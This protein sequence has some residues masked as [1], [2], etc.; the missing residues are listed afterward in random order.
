VNRLLDAEIAVKN[1]GWKWI[2]M[3]GIREILIP[4]DNSEMTN[5][6]AMW[7]KDG[8]PH[9]LP[10]YSRY[11]NK[12]YA[13]SGH[14]GAGKT[15]IMRTI[16]GEDKEIVSVTTRPMREGEVDGVDYYYI[17]QED[18]DKLDINGELAEKTTYYGRAS[19]GVTKAEINSKL[20]KSNTYIIVDYN[21]MKQLKNI[22]PNLVSIFIFTDKDTARERM[23]NRGDSLESVESRLTTY[24][25]E[26]NN[27]IDYDYTIKNNKDLR[28]TIHEISS[29]VNDK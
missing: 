24:D 7:D 4:P 28:S 20:S 2:N 12:L 10:P 8:I 23:I 25:I 9:F 13:I 5:W 11:T 19:Y 1:H 26:I 29:I 17:N 14:S 3:C 27:M 6:T 22:Y 15:S 16:M 18:F 21:G